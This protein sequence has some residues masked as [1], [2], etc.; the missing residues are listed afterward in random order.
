MTLSGKPTQIQGGPKRMQHLWSI[1]SIKLGTEWKSC[2]HYRVWNS[3]PSK[4]TPRTLI[5][6]K[7]FWFYGRFSDAMSFSRFSLKGDLRTICRFSYM[8]VYKLIT[9][10]T[11]FK[12]LLSLGRKITKFSKFITNCIEQG[13]WHSSLTLKCMHLLLL[14]GS[15]QKRKACIQFTRMNLFTKWYCNENTL[16]HNWNFLGC[17]EAEAAILLF[18]V[19]CSWFSKVLLFVFVTKINSQT[20]NATWLIYVPPKV[21]L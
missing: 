18:S 1:I 7:A 9:L 17:W 16:P 19:I 15:E 14:K 21:N 20:F 10:G 13:W 2:V 11:K 3:F 12:I 6:M 4:M 8:K 5:L